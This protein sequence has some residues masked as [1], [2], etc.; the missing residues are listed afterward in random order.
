M[1][2]KVALIL[3]LLITLCLV[4]CG[5]ERNSPA[6]NMANS[7]V[8][9]WE[10]DWGNANNRRERMSFSNDGVYVRYFVDEN[11]DKDIAAVAEYFF[12]GDN[13]MIFDENNEENYKFSVD[14]ECLTIYIED[15]VAIYKRIG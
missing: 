3:G 13:L 2:K 14:E 4:G 15:M 10:Q 1:K 5:K 8:G 7:I 12:E 9:I 6:E 11:G